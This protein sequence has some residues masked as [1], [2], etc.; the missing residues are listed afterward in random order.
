MPAAAAAA[1]LE[2]ERLCFGAAPD[3]QAWAGSNVEPSSRRLFF[4]DNRGFFAVQRTGCS[5]LRPDGFFSA[6]TPPIEHCQSKVA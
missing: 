5:N 6:Q 1:V 4:K 2:V 3:R